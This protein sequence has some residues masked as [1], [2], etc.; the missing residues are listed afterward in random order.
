MQLMISGNRDVPKREA[1]DGGLGDGRGMVGFDS[2]FSPRL[3]C[4]GLQ[5]RAAYVIRRIGD[6]SDSPE[7]KE[8]NQAQPFRAAT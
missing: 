6:L 7:S 4:Q 8:F 3:M 2:A 5:G 1:G